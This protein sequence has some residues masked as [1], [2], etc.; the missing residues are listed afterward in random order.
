[1]ENTVH[2]PRGQLHQIARKC[3][4]NKNFLATYGSLE[5]KNEQ[6]EPFCNKL[7]GEKSAEHL[8]NRLVAPYKRKRFKDLELRVLLEKL[9]LDSVNFSNYEFLTSSR[10][11]FNKKTYHSLSYSRNGATNSFCI[12]FN[13]NNKL[14]YANILEFI[15]FKNK[16]YALIKKFKINPNWEILPPISGD[17]SKLDFKDQ[18]KKFYVWVKED[19]FFTTLINCEDIVCKCLFIK[20]EKYSFVTKLVYDFEHD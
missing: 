19:D 17:L 14:C 3:I 13:S 15:E 12:C 2:G 10:C 6:L 7:I 11:F 18:F 8:K 20:T 5:F 4:S 9:D 1:M 16:L